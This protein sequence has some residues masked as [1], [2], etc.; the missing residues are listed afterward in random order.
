MR[1]EYICLSHGG[2][3]I[4]ARA[5]GGGGMLRPRLARDTL[6]FHLV[7]LVSDKRLGPRG[8]IVNK[9]DK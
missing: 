9:G 6:N 2:T 1:A 3:R 4:S 7:M 8:L 5:A